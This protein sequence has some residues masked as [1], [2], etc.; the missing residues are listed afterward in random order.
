[1]REREGERDNERGR[2]EGK[3][4]RE[5]ER[6]RERREGREREMESVCV[7][8]CYGSLSLVEREVDVMHVDADVHVLP[9][10]PTQDCPGR[11]S[12]TKK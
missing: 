1:M 9:D 5:K 4:Q 10:G 2:R 6:M 7:F 11:N 3:R 8:V 12:A